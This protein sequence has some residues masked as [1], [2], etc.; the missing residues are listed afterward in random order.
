MSLAPWQQASLERAL[1]AWRVGRLGHAQLVCGAEG[2][3]KSALA[4]ALAARLLC[5]A[6][7]E[8]PACGHCRA[9]AL[10]AAGTHPDC[11]IL[12][13]EEVPKSSPPRLRTELVVEQVRAAGASM[14]MTA[15]RGGAQVLIID[16]ADAL[17]PAAAN[18]LL[19][20]LEEPANNRYLLL[21]SSRPQRLSATIRSR[22]QRIVLALPTPAAAQ[23]WLCSQGHEA[24]SA[25][26]A[27]ALA[28]GHPALADSW[29]RE[30]ALALRE[31]TLRDWV[32]VG[33]GQRAALA[34]AQSWLAEPDKAGLRLRFVADAALE[35]A[36]GSAGMPVPAGLTP[37]SDTAKLALWFDQL[38]HLRRQ[39]TAPLKH[40]LALAGLLLEWRRLLEPL[41]T[42]R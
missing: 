8:A 34:V 7:P 17:N 40:E 6:P 2:M 31:A 33:R 11:R 42:P 16:P 12:T 4:G 14:Q 36:R 20:T 29:L 41:E 10:H 38:N 15:Q 30:G 35:L 28:G 22:C 37:P 27:L 18:A 13:F 9:C 24:G 21:L 23:D 26:T 39:L 1:A 3:G 32:A 25:S 19:K 5:E